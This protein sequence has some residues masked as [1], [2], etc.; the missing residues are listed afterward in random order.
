[1]SY[2]PSRLF[3]E[4]ACS[5]GINVSSLRLSVLYLL[6]ARPLVSLFVDQADRLS[7]ARTTLSEYRVVRRPRRGERSKVAVPPRL[8]TRRLPAKFLREGA[9]EG[10]AS[11]SLQ[12]RL[13]GGSADLSRRPRPVGSRPR[14]DDGKGRPLSPRLTWN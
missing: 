8:T 3:C 2:D 13:S 1:M 12:A 6:A 7:Q 5:V 10:A 14:A 4:G 11:A 9:G